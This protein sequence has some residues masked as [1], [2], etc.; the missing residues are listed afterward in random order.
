MKNK[1]NPFMEI[2]QDFFDSHMPYSAGFSTNTIQS[3]KYAFR[4]LMEYLYTE[5][6]IP[7]D[8]ITFKL[9][10][11]TVISDYLRWLE[12]CRK[13]SV[14]TRNQRLAALS[15]FAAYAQN[16]DFEAAAIFMSS[17]KRLPKKKQ[18]V[19]LR[20]IFTL[21]EVSVLLRLPDDK[22]STGMRDKVL[23]NVMY[24][25][26]ARAQEICD[27]RVRDIQKQG[28]TVRMTLMGKGKKARRIMIAKQCGILLCQYLSGRRLDG[29]PDSHIFSSQTHEHMTVS[30]V[31]G[32]FK[33]YIRI[34]RQEYPSMF[35]DP[36][37]SP[38]TM[39]H[40]TA[41]HMLEAGIPI[42]AIKN[43]LG[44]VSLATTQRYTELS[45]GTVNRHVREWNE[46]W[47]SHQTP[48]PQKQSSEN[49][50]PDF[51]M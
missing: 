6:G 18:K 34:A 39:R 9:L 4:L 31:E 30:C 24:A 13:C 32:I 41:T 49:R 47:F 48:I 25:S 37:Y 33:K 19:K 44:H 8:K 3:Y 28:D 17:L 26:G 36:H 38:H 29:K 1:P 11:Y 15:S 50:M 22:K 10:D 46:K 27:L 16:R 7:A 51:L 42:M 14:S 20:T 40:T 5:K 21:D 2:L 45:Q 35:L 12:E 43:F 23:L